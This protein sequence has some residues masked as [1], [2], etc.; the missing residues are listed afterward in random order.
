MIIADFTSPDPHQAFPQGVK[1]VP[2]KRQKRPNTYKLNQRACTLFPFFLITFYN[3]SCDNIYLPWV[4]TIHP[5]FDLLKAITIF[6][7]TQL[8]QCTWRLKKFINNILVAHKLC[9]IFRLV[10]DNLESN[11]REIEILQVTSN[12]KWM[13]SLPITKNLILL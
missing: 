11:S 13:T 3:L 8:L 7:I 6:W 4:K 10:W 5:T 12:S 1:V 9:F 2:A